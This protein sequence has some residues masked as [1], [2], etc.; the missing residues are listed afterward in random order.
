MCVAIRLKLNYKLLA[1][2]TESPLE[3]RVVEALRDPNFWQGRPRYNYLKKLNRHPQNKY[4]ASLW[5]INIK[6]NGCI[7][8]KLEQDPVVDSFLWCLPVFFP[9]RPVPPLLLAI[10]LDWS[11]TSFTRDRNKCLCAGWGW[12]GW[13]AAAAVAAAA[14]AAAAAAEADTEGL[15]VDVAAETP[16]V[17]APSC[18]NAPPP[19]SEELLAALPTLMLDFTPKTWLPVPP[20]V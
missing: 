17:L 4:V 7:Y 20:F 8:R 11:V 15:T 16:L 3:R 19:L 10:S 12:A 6:I 1:W 9:P 13:L 18:A 14:A 2:L 5:L